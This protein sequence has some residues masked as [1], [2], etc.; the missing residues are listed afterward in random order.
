M[1]CRKLKGDE[2][3]WRKVGIGTF[4]GLGFF[5]GQPKN[6]NRF[7]MWQANLHLATKPF[8]VSTT[9]NKNVTKKL[10]K[11]IKSSTSLLAFI[12]TRTIVERYTQRYHTNN[13]KMTNPTKFRGGKWHFN[14]YSFSQLLFY[15]FYLT[16]IKQGLKD[17]VRASHWE[18]WKKVGENWNWLL[19]FIWNYPFVRTVCTPFTVYHSWPV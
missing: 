1:C 15:S 11:N 14:W 16:W 2:W 5:F 9:F 3:I 17:S 19:L 10:A 12:E 7:Q 8:Y 6:T 18:G 13:T 4:R